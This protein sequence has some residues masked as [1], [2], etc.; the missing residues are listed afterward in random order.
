M[1]YQSQC[2]LAKKRSL[3][4]FN[5]NDF[6]ATRIFCVDIKKPTWKTKNQMHHC[7]SVS[8]AQ[9]FGFPCCH[10]RDRP[11]IQSPDR[12]IVQSV[13]GFGSRRTEDCAGLSSPLRNIS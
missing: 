13:V 11:D 2:R 8:V 5:E 6:T 10:L 4:F 7:R 1:F 9:N 3:I 12:R